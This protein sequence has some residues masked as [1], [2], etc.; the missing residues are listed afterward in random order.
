MTLAYFSHPACGEHDMGANHPEQPAR[1]AAIEKQL[2]DSGLMDALLKL[3]GKAYRKTVRL[4]DEFLASLG[5]ITGE[6][7]IETE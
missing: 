5:W 7:T 1:L 3:P 2:C 6:P 4:M